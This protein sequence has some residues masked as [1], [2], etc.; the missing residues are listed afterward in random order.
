MSSKNKKE[1]AFVSLVVIVETL[2]KLCNFYSL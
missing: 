1:I 2:I